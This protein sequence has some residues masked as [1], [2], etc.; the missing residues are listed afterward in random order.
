MSHLRSNSDSLTSVGNDELEMIMAYT[1][2]SL[3]SAIASLSTPSASQPILLRSGDAE[4]TLTSE[5]ARIYVAGYTEAIR[6]VAMVVRR[7]VA[8]VSVN[9]LIRYKEST[10]LKK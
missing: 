6:Q 3:V 5:Q 8:S 2:T 7:Q 10:S 1:S 9:D 4:V